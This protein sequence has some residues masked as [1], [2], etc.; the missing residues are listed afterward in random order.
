MAFRW[1]AD[2]GPTLNA[3]WVVFCFFQVVWTSI[4][5]ETY[6]ILIFQMG[7][8]G[9]PDTLF[10][11][12]AHVQCERPSFKPCMDQVHTLVVNEKMT[13]YYKLTRFS[14]SRLHSSLWLNPFNIFIK[15]KSCCTL[16]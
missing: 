1:W 8:S 13:F 15:Q 6:S 5:K 3:V 7:G 2:G 16:I 9:P 12:S 11:G 4:F 10:S 14:I